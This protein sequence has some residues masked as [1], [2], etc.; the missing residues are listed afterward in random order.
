MCGINN[1]I[2]DTGKIYIIYGNWDISSASALRWCVFFNIFYL[3]KQN[4]GKLCLQNMITGFLQFRI[5]RQSDIVSSHR[6][7][8]VAG[9]DHLSQIIHINRLGTFLALQFRFHGSL[10]SGFSYRIV[11]IICCILLLQFF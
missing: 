11:A 9:L 8:P 2:V 10:Y 1:I 3:I 6:L 7:N 5:Q 4:T